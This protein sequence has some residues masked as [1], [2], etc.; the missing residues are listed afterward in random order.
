ML[1]KKLNEVDVYI[2]ETPPLIK[3]KYIYYNDPLE[4]MQLLH[5]NFLHNLQI[6]SDVQ[7]YLFILYIFVDKN[8]GSYSNRQTNTRI[9]SSLANFRHS[10]ILTSLCCNRFISSGY[11]SKLIIISQKIRHGMNRDKLI[12]MWSVQEKSG[13]E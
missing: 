2:S 6:I 5:I 1:F 13:R 4:I 9:V 11:I 3:K 8:R 7:V 12:L 10:F